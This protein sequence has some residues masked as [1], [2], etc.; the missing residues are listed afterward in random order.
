MNRPDQ[1][2]HSNCC[3]SSAKM[4]ID[5]V[6][7]MRV[8]ATSP[9]RATHEGRHFGFCS[10]GCRTKFVNDP[11]NYLAGTSKAHELCQHPTDAHQPTTPANAAA[12]REAAAPPGT[13]Y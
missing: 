3:Q 10:A 7:G 12:P 4:S 6:C 9:H 8:E 1:H 5:P 2:Q 11:K 13:I